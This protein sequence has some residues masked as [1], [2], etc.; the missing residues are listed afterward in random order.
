[1][2]PTKIRGFHFTAAEGENT[3]KTK[4]LFPIFVLIF[5]LILAACSA[6]QTDVTDEGDSTSPSSVVS[7]AD[8]ERQTVPATF[9]MTDTEAELAAQESR[10]DLSESSPLNLYGFPV[11]E[12]PYF[13]Y[14][15]K[16]S[17]CLTVFTKDIH[18]F[19]TVE[20]AKWP[21]GTGSTPSMT[22]T[23]TFAIGNKERWHRWP[24]GNYSP[25]ATRYYDHDYYGG[26]FIHAAVYNGRSFSEPFGNSLRGIGYNATS[27]CLRTTVQCAYFVYNYCESGTLLRIVNGSPLGTAHSG[28]SFNSQCFDPAVTGT[29]V[30]LPTTVLLAEMSFEQERYTVAAGDSVTLSPSFYPE[31]SAYTSCIW[32][33]SDESVASVDGGGTVT[34]I[35]PGTARITATYSVD[36]SISA[37]CVVK[38][39]IGKVTE[40]PEVQTVQLPDPYAPKTDNPLPFTSDLIALEIEGYHAAINTLSHPLIELLG[41]GYEYNEADSCAYYGMDRKYTYIRDDGIIEISTIPLLAGNDT[42]CEI[43]VTCPGVT[44]SMGVGV[45]DSVNDIEAAYGTDFVCETISE[46]GMD[47][48]YMLLTYWAGEKK[49]PITPQLSFTLDPDTLTVTAVCIYSARNFG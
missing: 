41:D 21:T 20:V 13:I 35:K 23:G 42:V 16:G 25:Y 12:H 40:E 39:Q 19:Y 1:M 9:E 44:T 8:T 5:I 32:T 17:H 31:D 24:S 18:G 49:S 4:K 46:Y 10:T 7:E 26:L 48:C 2:Y 28:F 15:E 14:V 36:G 43:Y 30:T 37:S 3:V 33:S 6:G 38:V 27:G 11:S 29:G 45:G 34:G 22:P 47:D